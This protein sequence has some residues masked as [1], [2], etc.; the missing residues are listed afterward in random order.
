MNA[1]IARHCVLFSLV[2]SFISFILSLIA[3]YLPYWKLIELRSSPSLP[4]LMINENEVDPLIRSELTKYTDILYRRGMNFSFRFIVIH[5]FISGDRHRFGLIHHCIVNHNCGENRLFTFPEEN[6]ESCHN[7]KSHQECIFSSSSSFTD[8]CQCEKPFYMK[9]SSRLLAIILILHSIFF[10]S[11]FL[12]LC[13]R[14]FYFYKDLPL[15]IITI[16]INLFSC[17]FLLIILV[18][19]NRNRLREP[20][21][22]FQSMHR[23]YSRIQIYPLANNLEFIL[24]QLEQDF[25][26]QL[27]PSYACLVVVFIMT[28]IALFA[29]T[30]VEIKLPNELEQEQKNPPPAV[31]RVERFPRQTKV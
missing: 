29:S 15:R 1:G 27:G 25:H 19:Q 2:L 22:F 11:N 18:E 14:Q 24:K 30:F 17:V 23:H 10:F 8:R 28:N 26:V 3:F 7:I 4:V 20:L 21:E 31:R 6:Y 5:P 12:R 13:R 16:I 9:L